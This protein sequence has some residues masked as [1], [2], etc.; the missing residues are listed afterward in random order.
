MDNY[1]AHK[2]PEVKDWLAKHPRFNVHFTPTSCSW[3]NQVERFYR[4]LTE[5]CIRRGVFH[6]VKELQQAMR[7]YIDQHTG[8]ALGTTRFDWSASGVTVLSI[9]IRRVAVSIPVGPPWTYNMTATEQRR[10]KKR[11]MKKRSIRISLR[12]SI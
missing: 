9:D 10:R 8:S 7:D 12:P 3:L 5:K 6:S 1:S 2:T 11:S 4:D